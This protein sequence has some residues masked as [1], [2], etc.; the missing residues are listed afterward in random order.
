MR[1]LIVGAG[2]TGGLIGGYLARNNHAVT[3]VARGKHLAAIREKGLTIATC[4]EPAYTLRHIKALAQEEVHGSYDVIFVCVKAYSLPEVL[5]LLERTC[6]TETV[7]IP[8]Q[9]AMEAGNQLR[10]ALPAHTV[11]DGCIYITGYVAEPGKI[12]QNN[13][14]FRIVYGPAKDAEVNQRVL[15]VL[16]KDLNSSGIHTR[17]TTN[18]QAELFRKLSFTSAFASTSAYEGLKAEDLQQEGPYR[19]RFIRF[20]EELKRIAEAARFTIASDIVKDNVA[21]LDNLSKEFTASIQKDMAAG[22]PDE[23]EQLIFDIVRM[24]AHYRVEVPN[25]SQT[26]ELFG[27]K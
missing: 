2:G 15:D 8:I 17:F 22:R 27:L 20:S 6:T 18:I 10:A 13:R 1:Y 26:A 25:Y 5:P 23:R 9:N 11:L 16:E 21:I 4:H 24:A 7:I 19:D 12:V 14:I 3:L